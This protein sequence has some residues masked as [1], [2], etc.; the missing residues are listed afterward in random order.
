MTNNYPR[1]KPRE[2]LE[3][4]AED[5]RSF[6]R[7][8]VGCNHLT[9]C[10]KPV[11]DAQRGFIILLHIAQ[12]SSLFLLL[13]E[14]S[15][16]HLHFSFFG[17][18]FIFLLESEFDGRWEK[19]QKITVSGPTILVVVVIISGRAV[20]S[21]IN[22]MKKACIL[23]GCCDTQNSAEMYTPPSR[24]WKR[25]VCALNRRAQHLG[26]AT[27]SCEFVSRHFGMEDG[28]YG[29]MANSKMGH[30]MFLVGLAH[31]GLGQDQEGM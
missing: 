13:Q 14:S 9:W 16:K 12:C 24:E 23:M 10:M 31:P 18:A 22:W 20:G 25:A 21:R 26:K 27:V 15:Q 5:W 4:L 11:G 19:D 6:W 17:V 8:R 1:E 3:G 7:G 2:S 30:H 29:Q 28:F